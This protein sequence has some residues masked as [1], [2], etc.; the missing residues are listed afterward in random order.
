[1]F[2]AIRGILG[3][4]KVEQ[5]DTEITI[6]GIPANVM[7]N[8]ISKI[9]KTSRINTHMFTVTGRSVLSFPNFFAPDVVYMIDKLLE[10]RSTNTNAR[11]LNVIK[12]LLLTETWLKDTNREH[13]PRLDYSK[14]NNLIYKPLDYQEEFL[15]S[16][17]KLT[18]QYHLNGYLLAAA[19]GAGKAQPLDAKIKV[20][21]GWS[22]MGK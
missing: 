20:P 19:A 9:W 17:D 11:S 16:Y 2:S 21:G 22:T 1:M 6:S 18:Q 13:T 5:R 3:A 10:H 4:I 7:M 15:R 8:D 14:I 12:N